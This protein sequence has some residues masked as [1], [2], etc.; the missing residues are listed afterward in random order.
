MSWSA[1]PLCKLPYAGG[2]TRTRMGI[3]LQVFKSGRGRASSIMAVHEDTYR[4]IVSP[5][6]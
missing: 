5:D 3:A 6:G 1:R 2:G 4:V